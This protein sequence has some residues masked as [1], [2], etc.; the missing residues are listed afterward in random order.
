M[1]RNA[2]LRYCPPF[3]PI[4]LYWRLSV[5]SVCM[6]WKRVKWW[7]KGR[8]RRMRRSDDLSLNCFV[9]LQPDIVH[10]QIPCA[11]A[12]WWKVIIT[13]EL[14]LFFGDITGRNIKYKKHTAH[15]RTI[16]AIVCIRFIVY[17]GFLVFLG[18]IVHLE[19]RFPIWKP[20]C[21]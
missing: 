1:F 16:G 10:L 11:F 14:N 17:I 4:L 6:K 15:N 20:V 12:I 2:S 13:F 5:V 8:R 19:N 3:S 7:N 21:M 18:F 9:M